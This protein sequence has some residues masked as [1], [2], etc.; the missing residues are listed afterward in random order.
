MQHEL[1]DIEVPTSIEKGTGKI[2][3]YCQEE[4]KLD[5]FQTHLGYKDKL[6]IR[7]RKCVR[8]QAQ[9]RAYLKKDAPPKSLTC[10]C[11]GI[12][13]DKMVLDHCHDTLEFRGWLCTNC[14]MG[15][16]KLGDKIEGIQKALI[17]L[18][19]HNNKN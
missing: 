6:D 5:S 4:K 12:E 16:G 1:F 19:K 14:N 18:K 2:C 3:V 13:T 8:E 9:V 15:I 7:C 17:Y 10:N 11:C